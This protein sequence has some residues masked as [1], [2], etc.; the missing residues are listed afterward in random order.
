MKANPMKEVFIGRRLNV[1]RREE[2]VK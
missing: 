1:K 2:N